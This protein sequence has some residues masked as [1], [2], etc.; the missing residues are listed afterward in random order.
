MWE[1]IWSGVHQFDATA[2][3]LITFPTLW[4]VVTAAAYVAYRAGTGPLTLSNSPSLGSRIWEFFKTEAAVSFSLFIIAAFAST[5]A[6]IVWILLRFALA[7]L[8]LVERGGDFIHPAFAVVLIAI[9]VVAQLVA[10]HVVWRAGAWSKP[11]IDDDTSADPHM[12]EGV[13]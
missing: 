9:H 6:G 11:R 12:T 4:I 3:W 5:V 8:G 2:F 10:I 13:G 7:L 1:Q